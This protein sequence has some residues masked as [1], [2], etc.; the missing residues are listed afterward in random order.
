[1]PLDCRTRYGLHRLGRNGSL[2]HGRIDRLQ[3][4]RR[5][6]HCLQGARRDDRQRNRRHGDRD[7]AEV[8]ACVVTMMAAARVM[9]VM[10]AEV[11]ARIVPAAV[12]PKV[13]A[14]MATAAMTAATT[15]TTTAFAP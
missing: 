14:A 6:G 12:A 2:P 13:P 8:T 4:G 15:A 9:T 7:T 3:H 11:S 5:E 10:A 1:M